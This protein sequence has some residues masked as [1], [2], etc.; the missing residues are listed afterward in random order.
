MAVLLTLRVLSLAGYVI[1]SVHSLALALFLLSICVS[2]QVAHIAGGWYGLVLFIIYVTGLLVCVG[3]VISLIPVGFKHFNVWPLVVG[4]GA[5]SGAVFGEVLNNNT[6]ALT[7]TLP[8]MR[9]VYLFLA[10]VLLVLLVFTVYLIFSPPRP[11]RA[12]A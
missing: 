3:Y 5:P 4:V 10:F 11:V 7:L 2:C 1:F 12:W 8:L 6:F 9:G